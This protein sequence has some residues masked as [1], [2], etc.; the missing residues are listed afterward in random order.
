EQ[1][2]DDRAD[3]PGPHL[4]A[5]L[6]DDRVE[7]VLGAQRLRHR[8]VLRQHADPADAPPRLAGGQQV[9]GVHGLV[10]A[11]EG[12]DA[13]VHDPGGHRRTVVGGHLD[14]ACGDLL[15]GGGAE[16]H[17]RPVLAHLTAP[18]DS[19]CT[20]LSCAANPAISTGSDTTV[21]AAQTCARN[22]PWDVT[23]PVRYTGAVPAVTPVRTRANSISFHAKMKQ[24]SAV[25]ATPGEMIG[26]ITRRNVIISPAPSSAAASKSA[27]G[28]STR[29]DRSIHTAIGRFIAA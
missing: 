17:R 19:P 18:I 8:G 9:V 16:R 3:H 23:N 15:Q 20:S 1:V 21:A 24:I 27:G 10:H 2:V 29:K 6:H 7:V 22:C 25:A 4:L 26:M 14:A 11:V 28:M 13:E 5:A 12:P